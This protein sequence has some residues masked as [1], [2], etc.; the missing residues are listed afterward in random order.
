MG[1]RLVVPC[2]GPGDVVGLPLWRLGVGARLGELVGLDRPEMPL[3]VDDFV[4]SCGVDDSR[5]GLALGLGLGVLAWSGLRSSVAE[6]LLVLAEGGA[7]VLGRPGPVRGMQVQAR[8]SLAAGGLPLPPAAVVLVHRH[9]VGREVVAEMVNRRHVL[10][11]PRIRMDV[12]VLDRRLA[13][14][15][16]CS[17]RGPP[18]TSLARLGIRTGHEVDLGVLLE[19]RGNVIRS[20][21][22]CRHDDDAR[23]LAL[24]RRQRRERLRH[25]DGSADRHRSWPALV[26]LLPV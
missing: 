7:W 19:Q 25:G 21:R 2:L 26:E 4:E 20:V 12:R 14:P 5:V 9:E 10:L 24:A 18:S 8:R 3:E 17:P 6:A 22:L 11:G 23:L 1:A 15:F 16:A 13:S